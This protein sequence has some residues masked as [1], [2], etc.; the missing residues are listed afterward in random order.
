MR[1]L[2]GSG[3][4]CAFAQDGPGPKLICPRSTPSGPALAKPSHK[5]RIVKVDAMQ[6]GSSRY[7]DIPIPRVI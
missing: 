4:V 5:A 1:T 7:A 2:L 3:T 6:W